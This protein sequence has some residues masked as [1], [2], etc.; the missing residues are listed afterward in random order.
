MGPR[1]E[2]YVERPL[3]KTKI[4]AT[5]GPACR[6]LDELRELA[7][8]GADLFRLNFA[9]GE[10]SQIS[11][12]VASIR[13]VSEEL[14]RPIAI[15]GDLAGPKIRLGNLP[16][17]GLYCP[18]GGRFEFVR[19]PDPDDPSRLTCTYPDLIDDLHPDDRI[20]LADGTVSMRVI[21]K[22]RSGDRLVCRVEQPGLIRTR[23][24][25]NLPG[26]ELS[27]PSLTDKDLT[28]LRWAVEHHL[29]FVGL[30]FVRRADDIRTL[31][32]AIDDLSP[33]FLPQII[34]KIE[35]MEAVT[36]LEQILEQADAVMVARGDLG[37]EI[38]IARVPVLQKR[39]IRMCNEHRIPVITAT[40][41]LDSMQTN[42]LPTRAE[43]SDVA[44]AVLDG[45]DAVMLSGET[46]IGKYPVQSVAMMSRIAHDVERLVQPRKHSDVHTRSSSRARV[47]T[48]A[49]TLGAAAAAENLGADLIVVATHS[50]RTAMAVSKQ[51]SPVPVLALTDCSETARRMCLYWGITSLE[52]VAVEQ[53]PEKLLEFV[54]DWGRREQILRP[55][56]RIVLVGSSD[57]S[58][59][60][61]NLML[62]HALP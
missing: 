20:L 47:V 1:Q 26:I 50:G 38:D 54:I 5:V 31:R 45:S 34:A 60:G 57:W 2:N 6:Q 46:A 49:V 8:A 53:T 29:D 56:S 24:G 12:V 25:I 14:G 36:D 58:V 28:D 15:L 18:E 21:E 19:E 22:P 35:K 27:T 39:I 33:S 52:T 10:H 48:E 59:A 40:Q 61:H 11:E 32:A 13:A 43:V 16:D 30:S 42:E 62:V 17:E 7:I 44:N 55:G 3:V 9:H 51:R 23:Q 37:V 4:I 41:M